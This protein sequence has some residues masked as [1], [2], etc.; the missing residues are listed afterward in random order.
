MF[1]PKYQDGYLL[2][3]SGTISIHTDAFGTPSCLWSRQEDFEYR[4][5]R[6]QEISQTL[7]ILLETFRSSVSKNGLQ[8]HD[9]REMHT[10]NQTD[11]QF[12]CVFICLN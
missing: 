11:T 3:N 6:R 4:M 8:G 2:N 5:D 12:I 9:K 1:G 10:T 7:L